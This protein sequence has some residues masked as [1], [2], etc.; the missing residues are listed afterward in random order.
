MADAARE[1]AQEAVE[2]ERSGL[3]AAKAAI[4]SNLQVVL[5]AA[6]AAPEVADAMAVAGKD[7]AM[8]EPVAV[9]AVALEK[10]AEEKKAEVKASEVAQLAAALGQE[11]LAAAEAAES[12][13]EQVAAA[14]T[15]VPQALLVAAELLEDCQEL[16]AAM[17]GWGGMGWE[18]GLGRG[19]MGWVT[20]VGSC[21][22]Y[23]E[24]GVAG[25]RID[26]DKEVVGELEQ[27]VVLSGY[28]SCGSRCAVPPE[29]QGNPQSSHAVTP[30]VLQ[31]LRPPWRRRLSRAARSPQWWRRR[32]RLWR[33]QRP[34]PGLLQRSLRRWRLRPPPRSPA[35]PSPLPM[36]W[37]SWLRR[38]LRRTRGL[39]RWTRP[40]P[41]PR[42][43]RRRRR[44]R[45]PPRPP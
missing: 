43:S 21:S 41:Q 7:K 40:P 33:R 22:Q 6:P 2:E 20:C 18:H 1:L 15:N 28:V 26:D 27:R 10:K 24:C 37:R 42:P 3:S 12:E 13:Q 44:P 16:L 39:C 38:P 35:S 4:A 36:S 17:G 14:L 19:A 31:R 5:A 11:A 8:P 34:L 29:Q 45:R 25:S 9:V 30:P 23:P 32:L